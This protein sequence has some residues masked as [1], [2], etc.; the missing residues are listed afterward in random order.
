M[1][2]L[3]DRVKV[4]I[5]TTGTGTVTF[6]AASSNAFLTP[7]EAGCADADTVRYV[8]VDGTDFEEGIGTIA[9]SVSTMERTTV[10]KSKIG[11]TAG[12]SKINLSG[13]AV[14]AL[15]A[16]AADIVNPANNLSDLDDA[17]TALTNLGGTTVGKAVFTATDAATARGVIGVVCPPHGRLTLQSGAPVM[18]SSQ[19]NKDTIYYTPYVGNQIPIYDGEKA[20]PMTFAELST[21]TTDTTHNPAAIVGAQV[22]DW[23]VW[24]D[25]GTLRLCHG[26]SWTNETTRSAGTELVRVGAGILVNAVAITNGPGAARGTY[27]GTTASNSLSLLNFIYGGAASGG[28]SAALSVWN[29]YNRRLIE[30]FLRDTD[31]FWTYA[32]AAW[33]YAHG[34][35]ASN[36]IEFVRGLNEDG[37]S[38]FYGINCFSTSASVLYGIG[39]S[40]DSAATP[41]ANSIAYSSYFSGASNCQ[42]VGQAVYSGNPGLGRHALQPIEYGGTG[43]T[44]STSNSVSSQIGGFCGRFL[45]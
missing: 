45:C 28:S 43:V 26:P 9:S 12:T 44:F 30:I 32:T 21:T 16:S 39:I 8:I 7:T 10:T 6:G 27:V 17:S 29:M 35:G 4:N 23:F 34:S 22:H 3:F 19:A 5:A 42:A 37:V 14:L 20:V 18:T 13:T 24:N 11:G 36:L 2:K 33:R 25:D 40:Q 38:A 1:A 15:T 41:A 31:S